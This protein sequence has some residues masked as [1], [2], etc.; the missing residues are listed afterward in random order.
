MESNSAAQLRN[1]AEVLMD[2]RN[3]TVSYGGRDP[4]IVTSVKSVGWAEFAKELTQTPPETDDKASEG[5]YIPAE[6]SP[7]YR[8]GENFRFR[9]ALTLDYD[10]LTPADVKTI[11]AAFEG[12]E[13]AVYTTWSHSAEKPRMRVVMP[14]SRPATEDEFCA[15]SRSVADV[16]GIELAARE[17]HKAAQMMFNPT[18]KLD[19]VFRGRVH[20]GS[21]V[22]VDKVLES[23]FDWT[24]K[25]SWPHRADGDGLHNTDSLGVAPDEKPGIVGDFC[26]QYDVVA[27][28]E[29]FELPYVPTGNP[30]RYTYAAGSRPEGVVIYDHGQKLHSHHDTDPA[31]GQHNAFDLVRLHRFGSEDAGIDDSTPVTARPSFSAM[32]QFAMATPE[33]AAAFARSEFAPVD[34]SERTDGFV[35]V[36]QVP[37][38]DGVEERG[39]TDVKVL[40]RRVNDLL[41]NPT[42]PRW[43]VRDLIERAVI[44]V[45]A[46]KRGSYKSFVALKIAIEVA[47]RVGPV[48]YISGEGGDMDRRSSA[49]IRKYVD[50]NVDIP[51]YI[52][53]KRMDLST[54]EGINEIRADCI[55]L[56]IKPVLFVLDTYSKLSGGLDENDNTAVK[57][58]IGRLD[59]GLKR[60]DSAFDATVLLI[61]HTGHSDAGRPRGASALAA[62][63]DAEYIAT[64]DERTVSLTRERFKSSPELPPLHYRAEV[65]QL[66]Y[67]DDDGNQI[68]SLVLVETDDTPVREVVPEVI[69]VKDNTER[70]VLETARAALV[71][72]PLPYED[73]SALVQPFILPGMSVRAMIN[74]IVG[75]GHLQFK[76]N[77]VSLHRHTNAQEVT[78][79]EDDGWIA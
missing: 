12:Y 17:S 18:R 57:A 36:V 68:T 69:E 43:L 77:I 2:E 24:D 50:G 59:I 41:Q 14:L 33:I 38:A 58:Y 53:E 79:T 52:V 9:H 3:L 19:A 1:P 49:G 51:L 26:R 20:S 70:Q 62:D 16:A 45:L 13:Y 32:V 30:D 60:A 44:A 46:G 37:G 22:N 21:W 4:A 61:A 63:T 31:R 8:H 56:G 73:L 55:R 72:G 54:V 35:E 29:K 25:T 28:I 23:Y 27:A 15:V 76:D 65:V 75:K 7:V 66:G 74:R 10:V 47:S 71:N 48:Y 40:A 42:K 5:W 64:K 39:H 34:E 11:L 6:F 78:L 67:C